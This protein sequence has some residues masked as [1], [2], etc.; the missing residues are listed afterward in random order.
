MK[1]QTDRVT[2]LLKNGEDPQLRNKEGKAA[3]DVAVTGNPDKACNLTFE[4]T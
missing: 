2:V 3:I 4:D 1:G